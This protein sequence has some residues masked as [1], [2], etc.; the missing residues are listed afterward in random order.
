MRI[1]IGQ[2]W[3]ET[4][5]FNR[6]FTTR[7]DF[8]NWGTA[9]GADVLGKFGESGELGGFTAGCRAWNPGLELVGLA[10]L[11]CWPWGRVDAATWKWTQETFAASLQ[12]AGKVDGVLL[13]LHGAM[14]AEGE[15]DV[16]GALLEQVRQAVGPDVP[17]V[18][19]LDLH[20]NITVKMME[21]A[22]L[23]VGYH[24]SPHLDHFETGERGV[25]GL[26]WMLEQG[27]RPAKYWRKLPMITPAESHN[28][29]T[30]P[31][32]PL[33]RRLEELERDPEV[34]SAGLYMAMPWLDCKAL[35]WV[36]TLH[37]ASP[38]PRWVEALD[39]IAEKCWELRGAMSD[40]ERF[41]AAEVVAKAL[42]H[43]GHPIVIGDGA[44]ATNSGSPGD[45]T[46]LL[47]EFLKQQ[48][49]PHGALTFLVDPEAV[50]Q[51]QQL[52]VGG[53]FD[54]FVGATFAPEFSEPL[55]FR[56]TVERLLDVQF[57]LDGHGG[58]KMPIHMGRGA[59]VRSGDVTVLFTEKNG[60]GSSPL[61]YEA[62][63]LA[64]RTCG[65]VVAKSPAGFRADYDP[66]V[67]AAFLADCPGCAT[68]NWHRLRFE[69]ID[70]PLWPLHEIARPEEAAW[71]AFTR[72]PPSGS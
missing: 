25:R 42:A 32:A 22:D 43:G 45:S 10:R 66:F 64:P 57:V 31:P 51:A 54:A 58:R 69:N 3:Q 30:G 16:T 60:P 1:A 18:G 29:F 35:G 49:I 52:G 71:C 39:D 48:P 2:L 67:A 55:R 21:Q 40:I 24:T 36:V 61:L 4:N 7:A 8:Q 17:I 70:R 33:Y 20:A 9:T 34:L 72:T 68:P 11:A 28:T 6:N 56:G 41:S 23:L 14:A 12:A 26:R 62:A 37:T 50:T 59:V 15:D 13:A 27:R 5:T 46:V 65:I 53:A 38:A 63:G 47:R 44:D 19:T